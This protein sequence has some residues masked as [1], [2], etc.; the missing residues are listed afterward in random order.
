MDSKFWKN[1]SKIK[2]IESVDCSIAFF[3]ESKKIN[4]LQ[5]KLKDSGI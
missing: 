3:E 2:Q 5:R 1:A 4:L